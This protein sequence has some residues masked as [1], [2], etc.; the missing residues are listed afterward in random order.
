MKVQFWILTGSNGILW[1]LQHISS[2]KRIFTMSIVFNCSHDLS[3][4]YLPMLIQQRVT[5]SHKNKVNPLE[6]DYYFF[7][8]T[9]PHSSLI[10]TSMTNTRSFFMFFNN[11]T[12][13]SL[14]KTLWKPVQKTL[15]GEM[16]CTRCLDAPFKLVTSCERTLR[17]KWVFCNIHL[18]IVSTN[19]G[20]EI[21]YKNKSSLI[22]MAS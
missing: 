11:M 6:A 20:E 1:T 8:Y 9:C 5:G 22:K 13:Q 4:N 14:Q 21:L 10:L 7:A 2:W 19:C 12:T 3:I 15:H 18:Q 16:F 17:T